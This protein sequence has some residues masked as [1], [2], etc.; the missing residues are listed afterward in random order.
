M[1]TPGVGA[2]VWRLAVHTS[3]CWPAFLVTA[4]VSEMNTRLFAR[5]SPTIAS[6]RYSPGFSRPSGSM[7][8]P[9]LVSMKLLLLPASLRSLGGA[10]GLAAPSG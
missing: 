3:I 2:P 6:T 4:T 1:D 5:W 10:T 7:T 9:G 8:L